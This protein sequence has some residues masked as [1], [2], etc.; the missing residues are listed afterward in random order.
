MKKYHP[1]AV[2]PII[3]KYCPVP[4]YTMPASFWP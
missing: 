4:N 1:I 3:C 2:L